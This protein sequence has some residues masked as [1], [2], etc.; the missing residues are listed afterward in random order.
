MVRI[1]LIAV[2]LAVGSLTA[3]AWA[4]ETA[5]GLKT[6]SAAIVPDKFLRR[7]DAVTLFFE[8]DAAKSGPEDRPQDFVTLS[9]AHPG[10]Y[11]WLDARI[12]QFK[13]AEPWPPLTRFTWTLK[14]PGAEQ[15]KKH[16][17]DTLM[18]SPVSTLPAHGAKHL[19]AVET[20]TLT[21][22]DPVDPEALA[23]MISLELRPLPGVKGGGENAKS[24][25]LDKD[26]FDIKILERANRT[27]RAGYVLLFHDPVPGGI[28]ATVHLRLSLADKT[29]QAFQKISFSTEEPFQVT[30]F[31]C[32]N[33][34]YPAAPQGVHY[35]REQ[36][37]RCS[38]ANRAVEVRFN[39][40]LAPAGPIQAR[41][42]VRF[43]PAVTELKLK[44]TRNVLSVSGKFKPDTLYKMRLDPIAS[45]DK[46][47][48][49]KGRVLQMR[50]P[51][52]LFFYF[53]PKA[54]FLRWNASQ[55][56]VERYGPQMVPL[57]GRGFSRADLRIYPLD[58]LDRSFWPFPDRPVTVNESVRPPGPGEEPAPFYGPRRYISAQELARQIKALGSPAVSAIVPLPLRKD[59]NAAKFGLELKPFI[60]S[61]NKGLLPPGSAAP[62]VRPG[63]YLVGIR[64]LDA[65]SE[66]AWI[67]IQVTDL[68]LTA[69]EE[70]E[71]V[72]FI[73]TSLATGAPRAHA[74]IR[75][76]G[77]HNDRWLELAS[78]ITD[79]NGMFTWEAPGWRRDDGR[80][81]VRRIT[82]SHG[83]DFLVLDPTRP[84]DKFVDGHWNNT[85]ETWLQW[86]QQALGSRSESARILCH[87][88]SE[89]PVYRPDHDVHI[90]GYIRKRHKG[91]LSPLPGKG[92]LVVDGPDDLEWR[93]PLQITDMGSFYH[94]FAEQ[95]LPTGE[96]TAHFEYKNKACGRVSFRKEAYRLPKFEVKL[97]GPDIAG[98]D[99]AFDVRL[100]ATYYAGGPVAARPVRWR[101]SQFP[102]TWS[103]DKRKGF[104]Y[105]SDAR[106]S[107]QAHFQSTPVRTKQ[108]RTDEQ[109]NAVLRID[110]GMEPT[111]Q[112][113][114][115]VVETTVTGADDQTVSNT[116]RIT[117]LPP[118]VL[119]LKIPRYLERAQSIDPEILVAGADGKL[120]AGQRVAIRLMQRQW[121]S[122]L[123]ATDFSQGAAKYVTET[124]DEKIYETSFVSGSEPQRLHIPIDRSGVYIV[125]AE[126][127]D[128]LGRSQRVSLDLFAGG[129]EPV[130][131]SRPPRRTF[132]ISVEKN[133]YVPGETATLVLESPFQ[134]A[135]ALAIIE[136]PNGHNRYQWVHVRNGTASFKL[137]IEKR[138]MPK[139]PVHFVLMRGR[140][141]DGKPL[142]AG[143]LDLGKPATLAASKW[144][145]VDPIKNR[146]RVELKYPP[147]AMPGQEV[148]VTL[149]LR[150]DQKNPLA[151]EA[152]LWLVDQA[153][154]ALGREQRLDPLPD[155]IIRQR[156]RLA[157]RDTRNLALG[158]LPLQLQPGGDFG[159]EGDLLDKVTIRKDF[160]PVPY[161]NPLIKIWDDGEITLKVKLPDNLTNFKLRAKVVSGPDRFGFA[162]GHLAVRLPVIVQPSLPRFVRPGDEFIATAIG[163][164]VE[165]EGGPG[166]SSIRAEGLNVQGALMKNFEW[167][168]NRAL[169]IDYPMTVPAPIY[170]ETGR[171]NR[172]TVKI[173]LGVER[174]ADKARDAF[175]ADLPIRADRKPVSR[176]RLAELKPGEPLRLP[177]VTEAIRPGSLK[178]SLL[179]AR[180]SA[181]VR[182]AAGLD[183]L[184]SYPHG[185]TEQRVS[186]ARAHLAAK[187]FRDLLYEEDAEDQL[188]RAVKQTLA[189]LDS[190]A[191]D[192]G[193]TAYWPGSRGY[194][195]L[196]AWSVQFMLEARDAGFRIDNKLLNTFMQ[197][198]RQSLRSD[199]EY[200]ILGESY[201]ERS[202]ALTALAAAGELDSA[203][204]AELARKADY[205]NLESLA[206]TARALAQ[207]GTAPAASIERLNRKLWNGIVLRLYQGR[208][209]YGGLQKTASAANALILPSETRTLAEVLRTMTITGAKERK[210]LLTDALITLGEDD[211]WGSTNANAAALLALSEQLSAGGKAAAPMEVEIDLNA[212][213]TFTLKSDKNLH[214][215]LLNTHAGEIRL[216]NRQAPVLTL[217]SE[218]SYLPAADGS[219]VAAHSQ[220]FVV[221]RELLKLR[222]EGAPP[223]RILL[224]APAKRVEFTVADVIEEHIEVVNPKD[225]HYVAV[226]IPLAAGMEPLNP[227]LATAPPEAESSGLLTLAPSYVAYMDDQ[228]AY[229][230]DTLPKGAYHFYFRTRATIPGSFIQPAAF[231]EM[232]YEQT[233]N[234]NTNGVR[235]VIAAK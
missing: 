6:R 44:T 29:D 169:R 86:T 179:I 151:G 173:T 150:D 99:E 126:A 158:H 59:G 207:S 201:A 164:I 46:I 38:G 233:V 117:A 9:P 49:K 143:Q 93:Y 124:V 74:Q 182:M 157:I 73:V 2:L 40:G 214:R 216:T 155:F 215:L 30:H 5:S 88:F 161:Y 75:V 217:R 159:G 120:L 184:L 192:N 95:K 166:K 203:Y 209:I 10:A 195:S 148:D 167:P 198:L 20:F 113:R 200:Y 22:P 90:K 50:E 109:G 231:A 218:T 62:A 197:A 156:S 112:P 234:G 107:G 208:E 41:N 220:G 61:I 60:Q 28:H 147:K 222:E 210:Q 4:D 42:L 101:I 80:Y 65:K 171:L 129:D 122:H 36:A 170:T 118:F 227:N 1:V 63:T 146:V 39:A 163:R 53:P 134:Y 8:E 105:S 213:K 128:K 221:S 176:R 16:R 66:R 183:Y 187:R 235:V 172:H 55:G 132:S 121:H 25:W 76:E 91:A 199:Y 18:S 111:A 145:K 123:Q 19:E 14:E 47:T 97:H 57:E 43:S 110:P 32:G 100:T 153:V 106:F 33:Q 162:K 206:Q 139:I 82:V 98:L 78:G 205:L 11:I 34:Q 64:K 21:F 48:D 89:R 31:G 133:R 24:R 102:Y 141:G 85:R 27:D 178:R 193:L 84:P 103:P 152:V 224:D 15:I 56:I 168:L 125:E 229:Y 37:I 144:I 35:T 52:T 232:M 116:R 13:P 188:E 72:K 140:V 174:S 211:G 185:C 26:D 230:Y 114:T 219:A 12:L 154:L 45:A 71:Q 196:T 3:T 96:Y 223:D 136:D 51:G 225:R 186:R 228:M 83:D 175:A 135:R 79:L 181:L 137:R 204:A 69:V 202:W 130:T 54:G 108:G 149:R 104:R 70:A 190:V 212:K 94:K 180:Q 119:A 127:Y 17:L 58:P 191:D 194:V 177:A 81:D 77:A 87:L 142:S 23:E 189:W 67:R 226:V 115:Y 131:W 68:S 165:G 92:F 160:N 7:W 138:Y